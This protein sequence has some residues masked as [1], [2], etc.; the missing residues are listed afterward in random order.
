MRFPSSPVSEPDPRLREER[1]HVFPTILQTPGS[2]CPLQPVNRE[3]VDRLRSRAPRPGRAPTSTSPRLQWSAEATD[4]IEIYKSI[5]LGEPLIDSRVH[6]DM[7]SYIRMGILYSRVFLML[8]ST[9]LVFLVQ[10]D[11]TALG[12]TFQPPLSCSLKRS[13]V[14]RRMCVNVLI[15]YSYTLYEKSV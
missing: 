12:S 8:H 7:V 11:F 5:D 14:E 15:L 1:E 4:S 3:S 10:V 6:K 2:G 13:N 9:Y